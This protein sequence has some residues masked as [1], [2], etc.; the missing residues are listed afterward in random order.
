MFSQ[1]EIPQK[2]K[3]ATLALRVTINSH[4][5][6]VIIIFL[7]TNLAVRYLALL[8]PSSQAVGGKVEYLSKILQGLCSS[9]RDKRDRAIAV[10]SA[11]SGPCWIGHDGSMSI[12]S[13]PLVGVLSITC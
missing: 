9:I 8:N 5:V 1:T 4:L 6:G 11:S 10:T 3:A 7:G 2:S 13:V 12:D